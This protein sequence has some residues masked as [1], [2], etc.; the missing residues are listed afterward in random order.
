MKFVNNLCMVL[1]GPTVDLGLGISITTK[2]AGE[3]MDIDTECCDTIDT[4]A[5]SPTTS[6]SCSTSS[7]T[8]F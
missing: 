3:I 5:I 2:T 6:K 8:T 1:D 7:K 4:V